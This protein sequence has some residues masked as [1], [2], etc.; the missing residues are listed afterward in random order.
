MRQRSRR[1][2]GPARRRVCGVSKVTAEATVHLSRAGLSTVPRDRRR[3]TELVRPRALFAEERRAT[4]ASPL[5]AASC[6]STTGSAGGSPAGNRSD[7]DR[8]SASPGSTAARRTGG[9][10][11]DASK[12]TAMGRRARRRRCCARSPDGTLPI[13]AL[14][15][16]TPP[17]AIIRTCLYERHPLHR[18]SRGRIALVGDAAHP[19][20]PNLARAPARRSRTPSSWQT[21]WRR[22]RRRR[23]ARAL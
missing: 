14:V 15:A 17:E 18:L 9:P 22:P 8:C 1:G 12:A 16:A 2:V 5:G 6:R 11:R 10:A 4:Q 23:C 21:N 7:A 3:R 20:R 13:E 19:M